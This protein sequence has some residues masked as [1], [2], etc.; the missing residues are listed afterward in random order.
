M[1]KYFINRYPTPIQHFGE[2]LG[3]EIFIKRDDLTEPTLG[4][5]KVRKLDLFLKEAQRQKVDYVVTY[6]AA[7]SNH[8]RLTVSMARKL[9]FRV[10]L[11]LAK[12]DQVNYNGNFLIYDLYDTE[13]VWT[14]TDKV[15][16]TIEATLEGLREKGYKP[17]FIQGGGHGD[18]GTHAYKLAF[19]EILLQEKE[20]D[21]YFD[22]IF[23]ASGTGTTQ[24]GLIAGNLLNKS[25]KHIVGI[26]VARNRERGVEV[27]DDSIRSYLVT[28]NKSKSFSQDI[29]FL[30]HYIG[31]GYA[32]IYP[33]IIRTIK[34]VAKESSILLD[35]VYTGKAFYGMLD[36]IKHHQIKGKN[37]LFIHTGGIP[38]LFNYA[39]YFK[40]GI[41]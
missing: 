37:I 8:C 11:I 24:A 9:G 32:D 27:I 1:E 33:E 3:N 18:L 5:N 4:G 40:E 35:P 19:D 22:K 16:E 41:Q 23:H 34:N 14:D 20:L 26:S 21:I 29:T 30:D 31:K 12:T 7:Q 39:D 17:Y 15:P 38:L 2:Y 28:D 10:L 6:G 36:T 25:E 13:I